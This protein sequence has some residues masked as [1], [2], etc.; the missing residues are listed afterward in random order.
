MPTLLGEEITK[1]L[2]IPV[3]GIGAGGQTDG[4]VLV[5]HDILGLSELTPKF[6]K[7]FLTD[8]NSIKEAIECYREAVLSLIHI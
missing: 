4:Q 1:A 5:T 7:N 2:E 6:T 3:V 8:A